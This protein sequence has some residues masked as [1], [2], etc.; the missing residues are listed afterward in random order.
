[1]HVYFNG[2]SNAYDKPAVNIFQSLLIVWL[3]YG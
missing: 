2:K 1:M 3:N